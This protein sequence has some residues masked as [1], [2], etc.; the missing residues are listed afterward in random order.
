MLEDN[1]QKLRQC[2]WKVRTEM[3]LD[4]LLTSGKKFSAK[5]QKSV[6]VKIYNK[7][8]VNTQV[9]MKMGA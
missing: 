3:D 6:S 1:A 8:D 2:M 5:I 4:I 7:E 9:Y